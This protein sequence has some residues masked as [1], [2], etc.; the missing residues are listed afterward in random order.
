MVFN[1]EFLS[2]L[3]LLRVIRLLRLL[4]LARVVRSS[5]IFKRL[6]SRISL[7]Y[8]VRRAERVGPRALL[9]D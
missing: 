9:L 1:A 3:K 2:N 6:E 5:R 7:S 4:K 8:S